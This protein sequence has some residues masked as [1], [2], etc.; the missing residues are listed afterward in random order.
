MDKK[1]LLRSTLSGTMQLRFFY[2]LCATFLSILAKAQIPAFQPG[3]LEVVLRPSAEAN[4]V[5][6]GGAASPVTPFQQIKLK[7]GVTYF[8]ESFPG[9]ENLS[10]F[11]TLKFTQLDKT[12][13]LI[14]D[15]EKLEE[16][17]HVE[18]MPLAIMDIGAIPIDADGDNMWFLK[19]INIANWDQWKEM[20]NKEIVIKIAI[21]DNGVRLNHEDLRDVIYR[22]PGEERWPNNGIDD[23]NNGYIDDYMGYDVADKDP[24]A[25]PPLN[26]VTS[27]FFSHGTMVAGLSSAST[28]NGI[29]MASLGLN[30]RIIPVKCVSDV[31]TSDSYYWHAWEGVRYAIAAGAHIINCSWS[32]SSI[33]PGQQAILDE[34]IE[35]GIIIVASAGN[36]GKDK[37]SFP[38]AY[39]GVIA[40]GATN[41]N[42]QVWGRS[43]FG[44]Y[45]DVMAPGDN[46]YTTNALSDNSYGIASGT[47]F[48]APIVSG[49]IGLL[50]SQ[51]NNPQKVI[52]V[53][54]NGCDE[55]DIENPTK[56]G[57]MGSGR[58][59]IDRTLDLLKNGNPQSIR[60][61]NSSREILLY[62]NPSTGIIRVAAETIIEEL[63]VI[64]LSGKEVAHLTVNGNT[65]DLTAYQLKGLHIVQ[66]KNQD[67]VFTARV[68]FH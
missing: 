30:T 16:V 53:L 7:Y 60:D 65:A 49:F 15:L 44:S 47:S 51:E 66:V 55:I 6:S 62:P 54:K 3:V 20:A 8:Q 43:N 41:S 35:R 31:D 27:S 10:Q 28:D 67:G 58:I 29:G 19:K 4:E 21:V 34:A 57:L 59:N 50:L 36:Q 17:V 63:V 38:A 40:V 46:I 68:Y 12:E 22:N 26:R 56:V 2:V 45:I 14:A 39:E 37:L 32:Q 13:L 48:S 23:D 42:D 5:V 61:F 24:N 11:Y 64:D 1:C 52:S 33:T 9:F 18:R 25:N